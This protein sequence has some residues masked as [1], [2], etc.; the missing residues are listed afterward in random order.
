MRFNKFIKQH[1]KCG[2]FLDI[3]YGKTLTTLQAID[4]LKPRNVL[5]IAP[6]AIARTTW[7]KEVKK[8][9]YDFRIYS[10]VEGTNP[11]THKPKLFKL[12]ELIK[13]Y[14]FIPY[15]AKN[16]VN[17]FITS[18]DRVTHLVDWCRD[19]NTWPFHMI[20]CDEFH[21]FKNATALRTKSLIEL[22]NHTPRLVGLTGTPMPNSIQDL[23]SEIKILDGGQRLGKYI[24]H[25][26]FLQ[27]IFS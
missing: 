5:I 1:P 3:G 13:L 9:G 20:V 4:D 6:K 12:K 2:V 22:A 17:L 26:R 19:N 21:S 18:R 8:W 11:K 24:T 14:E 23:W 15:T 10:M 7:H 27:V 16:T 25:F